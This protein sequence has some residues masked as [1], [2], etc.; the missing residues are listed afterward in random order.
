MTSDLEA[1][2]LRW[3]SWRGADAIAHPGGT[4]LSHLRRTA[5]RLADWRAPTPLRI[6]GLCHAA[7]GTDGFRTSLLP[8][9]RRS[10]LSELIGAEAEAIVYSYA[11]VDRTHGLPGIDSAATTVRNRFSGEEVIPRPDE[12]RQLIVLSCANELDVLLYGPLQGRAAVSAW[13]ARC[14]LAASPRAA[15]AVTEALRERSTLRFRT[16]GIELVCS[17]SGRGPTVVLL[18]AGGERRDVWTP[19]AAHLAAAGVHS[20]AVDQRG[21]G[22]TG[23]SADRLS[24]LVDDLC[25]LLAHLSSPVV[26]V[27]CSLGGLVSLLA[28][29]RST[30]S[31][32]VAAIVLVDVVPD[33]DPERSR[34]YLR[35]IESKSRP[36]NWTLIDDVLARASSLR[37]AASR[38]N[39]PIALVWGEHGRVAAADRAR[40][41][42]LVPGALERR[43]AGAGHLVARD[44][45]HELADVLLELLNILPAPIW[46]THGNDRTF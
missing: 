25:A 24:D 10:A 14:S 41:R 6:A 7:Y 2:I 22:D 44:R 21:H 46:R 34:R 27:G 18:H 33:P 4:L 26:L 29:A 30:S 36:W 5:A 28:S 43:M 23:G 12:L 19:V 39:A 37:D 9:S 31:A 3:L 8:V 17:E 42:A 32:H 35:S 20:I 45:P 13:L 16:G 11:S 40:F 1:A 38:S 15:A